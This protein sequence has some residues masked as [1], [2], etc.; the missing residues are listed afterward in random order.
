MIHFNP[1]RILIPVDFSE[2]SMLAIKHGAFIAQF[3]KADLS[4]LHVVNIPFISQDLFLPTVNLEDQSQMEKKAM[5]KLLEVCA[6]VKK[7]YGVNAEGVIKVGAPN[8]EITSVAR[9]LKA[10]LIIMG[11]HGYSP[12]Q[13]ILIGSTA[14]KVI[15]H[16]PCPTMA[17]SN[18]AAHKGYNKIVMPFDT[19]VTS[20]HKVNF[21]LE[22][23]KKFNASVHCIALLDDEDDRPTMDVILRQ[24]EELAKEKGVKCSSETEANVK[25]RAT[26]TVNFANDKGADLI[27]IMTD[28]DAELSGL[29][30]GTYAQQV[31]HH[32][33]V[34][35]IAV[36]PEDLFDDPEGTL[37][38]GT[39][40]S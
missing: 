2:T 20:R 23:A 9:E 40:G 10:S 18:S 29:F 12:L 35:V 24:V 26:T 8:R 7:E 14:L 11:T 13:E 31:L 17:M 28:Q 6:D 25:N 3:T 37:L 34:P 21:T 16:A 1:T 27:V 38:P 36:R 33:K 15:T 30:L 5:Q 32:S 39:S 22:F 4:L 19:T